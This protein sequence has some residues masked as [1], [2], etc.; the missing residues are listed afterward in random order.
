MYTVVLNFGQAYFNETWLDHKSLLGTT[1]RTAFKFS[2]DNPSFDQCWFRIFSFW[3]TQ[4]T[5]K[6]KTIIKGYNSTT[7]ETNLQ[8]LHRYFS[9]FV[10]I[11]LLLCSRLL[12]ARCVFLGIVWAACL[13]PQQLQFSICV[14]TGDVQIWYKPEVTCIFKSTKFAPKI[15]I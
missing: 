15:K 9:S 5:S 6:G 3:K 14:Y 1:K 11:L 8:H 4:Q 7:L 13:N 12:T 10:W 2:K